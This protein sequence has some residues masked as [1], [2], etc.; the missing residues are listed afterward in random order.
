MAPNTQQ[1]YRDRLCHAETEAG[2]STAEAA[3][4]DGDVIV[5]DEDDDD[6]ANDDDEEED[7]DFAPPK[8]AR[9]KPQKRAR[10]T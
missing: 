3:D 9:A 4:D 10:R 6:D 2:P 7:D 8:P 1:T 5:V